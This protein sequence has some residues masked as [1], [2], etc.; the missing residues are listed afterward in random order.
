[1]PAI[2]WHICWIWY[3]PGRNDGA[4]SGIKGADSDMM[5]RTPA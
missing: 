1:M 3:C 4:D 5:V 2:R